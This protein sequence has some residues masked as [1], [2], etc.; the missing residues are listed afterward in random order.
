M[1]TAAT[2]KPDAGMIDQFLRTI[3]QPGNTFEIRA[4]RVRQRYGKPATQSGY[5]TTDSIDAAVKC[6]YA[7]DSSSSPGG[8]YMTINP[9]VEAVGARRLGRMDRADTGETTN[10]HEIFRRTTLLI[11]GDPVRPAGISATEDEHAAALGRVQQINA[12]LSAAGW[13]DPVVVDSGNGGQLWYRIDLPVDDGGLVQRCLAALGARYDDAQVHVDQTVFNPARIGRIPGTV[14]RKGDNVPDRP[15][16]LA[17][18]LSMPEKFEP[19]PT[20]LLE[21]LAG[22]CAGDAAASAKPKKTP[23][24]PAANSA[25]SARV[26]L[27]GWTRER[28]DSLIMDHLL[29]YDP[30][31]PKDYRGGVRVKLKTCPFDPAH[32]DSAAVFF[33]DDRGAAFK[34]LHNGCKDN[35]WRDMLEQIGVDAEPQFSSK[36]YYGNAQAFVGETYPAGLIHHDAGFRHHVG[37]HYAMTDEAAVRAALWRWL[38]GQKIQLQTGGTASFRPNS[39]TVSNTLDALK[40]VANVPTELR[41][42]CW[43]P[44]H[45]GPCA[46]DLLAFRNG[47]MHLP[48][49]EQHAHTPGLFNTFVLPFDYDPDARAPH[50]DAFLQTLWP[51]DPE[52]IFTLKLVFGYLL[53]GGTYLQKIFLLVGPKRSGKGTIA[54]VLGE[55]LGADAVC[56]PTLAGL[57]GPF[58]L[59]TLLDKR[60]ATISD[61]RLSSRA[62]QAQIAER[63]LTISGEDVVS[64][65]RKYERDW[66]GRLP[67]RFLI[68]TNEL[69]R[70]ADSSGALASRFIVLA[71]HR[72]F[73]GQEDHRLGNRL[74]AELPGIA[75]WAIDGWRELQRLGRIELPA[76]ARESMEE[77][78]DLGSPV[79]AFVRD[80]CTVGTGR[81]ADRRSMYAAWCAWCEDEGRQHPGTAESFGRDLHAV[82]PSLRTTQHRTPTGDRVRCYEGI[83]LGVDWHRLEHDG[84]GGGT[85]ATVAEP[86][87]IQGDIELAQAGTG[88]S[89][90]LCKNRDKGEMEREEKSRGNNGVLPVPSC[91]T[92]AA[93]G[94]VDGDAADLLDTVEQGATL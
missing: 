32:V 85:G 28:F 5:F 69:P 61:A 84:T 27:F 59:Q 13:P 34:C 30:G 52:S 79:A 14:N 50:W 91:A 76:S 8:I 10:D 40:A 24:Q 19:V 70:L 16:R 56:G 77:L 47:L 26:N 53:G 54:R 66:C 43:L 11:D 63:L 45:S 4:L 29:D 42:P 89:H 86:V 48:T 93:D 87:A 75:N 51:D 9:P 92:R 36:N 74:L 73:F 64:V 88:D 46:S 18:L 1:V 38:A 62:D 82:V 22:A 83:A 25:K 65:P 31:E 21:E 72:S 12:D 49:G 15:H 2:L 7:L 58:G 33:S 6:I 90:T 80:R 39:S 78:Y 37:T 3:V 81:S 60:L 71:M 41:P 57:A 17:R 44:G 35:K 67:T 68:L 20:D 94:M 23:A 55:L